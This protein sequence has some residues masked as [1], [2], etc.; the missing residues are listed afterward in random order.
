MLHFGGD[1][2]NQG[3]Q[4]L[5]G[6]YHGLHSL[7]HG[8]VHSMMLSSHLPVGWRSFRCML[9]TLGSDGS[10]RSLYVPT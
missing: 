9:W 5:Q 8:S 6:C 2:G 10:S 4:F 7:K 1:L 3:L